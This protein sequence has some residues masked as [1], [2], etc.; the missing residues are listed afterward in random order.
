MARSIN[1]GLLGAVIIVWALVVLSA[2]LV[3]GVTQ[4][5]RERIGKLEILKRE[6][7]ELDV[8]WGQYLL[9][10]S[11]WASYV[12][13]EREAQTSLDMHVPGSEHIILVNKER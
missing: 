6:S 4:D 3:V 5:V 10:Q 11:T 2:L 9:E 13:V 12:R 7:A 1:R 8:Q